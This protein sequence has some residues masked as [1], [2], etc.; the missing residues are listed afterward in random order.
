[1]FWAILTSLIGAKRG[2]KEVFACLNQTLVSSENERQG[3][4][5][6]GAPTDAE[7]LRGGAA[8][9]VQE[10]HGHILAGAVG[11]MMARKRTK[12]RKAFKGEKQM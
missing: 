5:T 8:L 4:E 6:V 11:R 9:R 10:H 7:D 2:L 12:K 3:A 1:M